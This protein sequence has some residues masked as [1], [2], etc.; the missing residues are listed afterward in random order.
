MTTGIEFAYDEMR[1]ACALSLYI[2]TMTEDEAHS[3]TMERLYDGLK[4][5]D[6]EKLKQLDKEKGN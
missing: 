1:A 4:Q 2:G 6:K 3:Q 5:L